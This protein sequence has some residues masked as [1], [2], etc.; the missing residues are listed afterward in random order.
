MSKAMVERATKVGFNMSQADCAFM[1]HRLYKG[2]LMALA[3]RD[4]NGKVF[5]I[6]LKLCPSE[7]E[8]QYKKFFKDLKEVR[9]PTHPR[10]TATRP[11]CTRGRA[12]KPHI[13]CDN[14]SDKDGL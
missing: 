10:A 14:D 4:G 2:Q 12:C 13:A 1:K 5:T 7:T 11:T 9:S 6:A 8:Q 3:G